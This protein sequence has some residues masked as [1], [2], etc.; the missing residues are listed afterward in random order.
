MWATLFFHSHEELL[1]TTHTQ[2]LLDWAHY[3]DDSIGVWNWTKTPECIAA[4]KSFSECL[5]L[6]HLRWEINQPT[7]CVNYLNI[8]LSIKDGQVSSTLFEKNLRLYLYLPHALAH[9]PGVLKGLIAGGLLCIIRL[10]SNPKKHH[11]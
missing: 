11:L 6:H 9:P 3:I 5:Q 8:M 7:T 4:F 2:F 10:M 1:H